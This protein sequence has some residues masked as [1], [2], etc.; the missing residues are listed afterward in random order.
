MVTIGSI[1]PLWDTIS[2]DKTNTK[3][4]T[5]SSQNGFPVFADVFQN[6]INNVKQTDAEYSEAQYLLATGQLDNP[7]VATIAGTKA[8]LSVQL[9]AELRNKAL[10]AYSEISRMSI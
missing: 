4:N 7:A 2:L 10:D 8:T 3:E 1:Q 9:L 6:A 5:A